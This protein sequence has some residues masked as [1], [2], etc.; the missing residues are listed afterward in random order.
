[1]S[2]EKCLVRPNEFQLSFLISI[3]DNVESNISMV[4]VDTRGA[5]EELRTAAV[6]QRRAGRRA[7]CLMIVLVIVT[8]VV[9]L[10]VRHLGLLTPTCTHIVTDLVMTA[11]YLLHLMDN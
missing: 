10:A 8:A 2:R 1:M 11:D 6:Y 5:S 9:L 7:A 4:E 3:L